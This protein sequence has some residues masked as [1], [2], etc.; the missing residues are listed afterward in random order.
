V[1][2]P[3]THL[4]AGSCLANAGPTRRPG[5][6]IVCDGGTPNGG[7]CICPTGF[8]LTPAGKNAAG[9][10]CVKTHAENCLGGELTVAGK[11][12]CNGQVVMSGETYALEFVNG[13]CVPKRCP[14]N[15]EKCVATSAKPGT[16]EVEEKSR[17]GPRE[18][19]DEPE[20]RHCAHGMIRTRAGCVVARRRHPGIYENGPGA[21]GREYFR[22]YDY[23]RYSTPSQN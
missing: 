2:P 12:L 21:F 19:S 8:D 17:P 3:N 11:C 6:N 9:G 1:C 13:K 16:P 4:D 14:V 10:R 15:N 5:D 22:I 7:T 20:R 18:S 23:P